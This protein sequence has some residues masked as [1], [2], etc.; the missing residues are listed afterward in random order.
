MPENIIGTALDEIYRWFNLLN[1]KYFNSALSTPVITIQKG[2]LNNFG[3]FTLAPV[4][5]GKENNDGEV[6]NPAKYEINITAE[7][8]NRPVD[9][10]VVTLQHEMVHYFNKIREIKDCSGQIHN[11]KFRESAE[12]LGL[13]CEKDKKYGWGIT[14]PSVEFQSF[15][16]NELK[17]DG[18]VFEYF[19]N[20]PPKEEGKEKKK[21]TFKYKCPQCGVTL[22]GKEDIH[23]LCANCQCELEMEDE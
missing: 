14:T 12:M 21:T 1:K 20:P 3:W 8:L 13:V 9:E 16:T 10:I 22:K 17:P 11:K 23:V 5:Q 2:R 15:V 4:W 7:N 18:A 19:R 6:N